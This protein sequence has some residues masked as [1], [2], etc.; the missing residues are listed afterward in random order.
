[1]AEKL[2]QL[3]K[4][5]A[6]LGGKYKLP[7]FKELNEEF[8]IE[9]VQEIETETLLR[10]IRK[11]IMDKVLAYLRFVEMFLNPTNAPLFFLAIM[12][13][14]DSSDKKVLEELYEKLGKME[15][16]VIAVDNEYSE[17]TEAEF[18]KHLC[19]E[20]R[21]VKE[22]IKKVSI[23]LEKCWDKKCEKKEKSYV[24]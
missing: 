2:N 6:K 17:K 4:D 11:V 5:Y 14:L 22:G 9:K 12:K 13:N 8:D 24:G 21:D 23:S 19:S 20:W 16:K 1:M 18:I 10:E 3:K 15:I 7:S